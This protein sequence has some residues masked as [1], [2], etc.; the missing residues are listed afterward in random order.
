MTLLVKKA[1]SSLTPR[2][3]AHDDDTPVAVI[4]MLIVVFPEIYIRVVL[5]RGISKRIGK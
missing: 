5:C 2:R 3:S 1:T 4:N